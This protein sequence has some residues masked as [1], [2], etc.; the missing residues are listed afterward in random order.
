M[1]PNPKSRPFFENLAGWAGG[2]FPITSST[3][4]LEYGVG[5]Y[6]F[7]CYYAERA[8]RVIGLDIR[9]YSEFHPGIEFLV[10]DG[11]KIPLPDASVDAVASH[12][13]LEHVEDIHA[14]LSEI[15]RVLRV[16]GRAF[17]TISPLY[18]S[19]GGSHIRQDKGRLEQWEHLDPKSAV[20]L[21]ENPIPDE[22]DGGHYLNK[23]RVRDFLEAVGTTPWNITVFQRYW[24]T[25]PIPEFLNDQGI[26]RLDLLTREFRFIGIKSR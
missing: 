16:G 20:Y 18:Y 8:G 15:D 1:N 22:P 9:D 23:L 4:L 21:T 2:R 26:D 14:S 6:G 13:V 25:K 19:S 24:E 7:A 17:L 12:S 10:Y 5:R 3:T 11:N